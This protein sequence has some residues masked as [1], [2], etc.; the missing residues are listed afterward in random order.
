MEKKSFFGKW[1]TLLVLSLALAII[2]IDTTLLN[3]SLGAIIKDFNTDIQSIQWV[4]TAYSL[5]LAAFTITGGRLGDFFGRKKM[6]MIGAILFAIGSFLASIS[7]SVG[8][9]IIGESIIEGFGAALM[10]PAT[11]SLLITNY[12]GKDRGIAFGVWGA[13][14]GA[15]A[16]IGPI[17]GGFLTT[18]YS[19]RW[20]FR[21]NIVIVA[22]LL[23]GSVVIK[24][25]KDRKI[26]ARLDYTGIVL[27]IIGLLFIVYGVIESSDYGWFYAKK[28]L[29]I[30]DF[31]FNLLGNLSFSVFAYIWG[32]VFLALF[33]LWE[34]HVE[35]QGK[36]PL[37]SMGIF[38]NR[39][40]SAGLITM[41]LMT[42]GQAG[43]I[44]SL[45]V[46]F[47]SVRKFTA[48]QTGYSLL[49]MSLSLLVAAPLSAYIIQRVQAR[50]VIIFGLILNSIAFLILG[51]SLNID[52]TVWTL[53]PGLIVY[54][55]GLGFGIAQISNVTLSAVS[56]SEA[57][58][59][60][61]LNSTMRQ[62]GSTFGSAIIGAVLLSFIASNLTS[63]I[64]SST[65]I[66]DSAKT[67]IT[68][69][70]A[71]KA[72]GIEFGGAAQ[73]EKTLPAPIV[74]DL[75]TISNNAITKANKTTLYYAAILPLLAAIGAFFLPKTKELE[76]DENSLAAV[77]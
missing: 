44:F 47:Q 22:I 29:M 20:G 38:K 54:G 34:I 59:A 1:G 74:K 13:I 56:R 77:H 15:S 32:F 10:M 57:G 26:R 16:A 43:I 41:A 12:S 48:L 50:S 61:G 8:T 23:L 40:F 9:L 66:P 73:L 25:A 14:A 7:T 69:V 55:L 27:S 67:Q 53:A 19:W 63:G 45:P 60:S 31:S 62:V 52:A 18:N 4:I 70:L 2:I 5:V 37:V 51:Y 28:V 33:F 11:A 49:P 64:T 71:G 76:R 21:I 30:G 72:S 42:L 3:V 36:S 6:F 75:E 35:R 46:F 58:E 17:L 24:E 65:T 68:Q 39:Q